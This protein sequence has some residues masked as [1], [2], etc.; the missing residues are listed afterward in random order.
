MIS[1]TYGFDCVND[2]TFSYMNSGWVDE[3]KYQVIVLLA[4]Y[5]N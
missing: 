4:Y 3:K 1:N 5:L 2:K